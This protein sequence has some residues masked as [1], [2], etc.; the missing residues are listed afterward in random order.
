[1]TRNGGVIPFESSDGQE[2]YYQKVLGNSDVW[3][4]PVAGGEETR[5][6]GPAGSFQFAVVAGGI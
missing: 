6:F 3:R 2:L 4:V 1:M 5:V